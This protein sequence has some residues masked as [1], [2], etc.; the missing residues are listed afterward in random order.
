MPLRF[1]VSGCW[2]RWVGGDEGSRAGA[3]RRVTG[4]QA[5]RKK[6]ARRPSSGAVG[7]RSRQAKC[8]VDDMCGGKQGIK[9]DNLFFFTVS[10]LSRPRG[11]GSG[12]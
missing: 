12:I 3:F 8:R 10:D 5:A 7:G 11:G 4:T 9:K 1:C 2:T 6:E